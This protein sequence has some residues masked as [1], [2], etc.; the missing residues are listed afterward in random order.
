MRKQ[1]EYPQKY[2]YT[3]EITTEQW[4]ELLKNPEVFTEKDI[5]LLKKIYRFD[6]HE[7]TCFDLGIQD[8]KSPQ[9]YNSPVVN[10]GKRISRFL[11]LAP[12]LGYDGKSTW[13]CILF[14]GKYR[15]KKHF[16]WRIRPELVEAM[17]NVFPE[18]ENEHEDY[19]LVKQLKVANLL[20]TQVS[21]EYTGESQEKKAFIN[22]GERKIYP[23]D[24][25]KAIN[26]LAH[27][28]FV[29]EINKGH[30]TFIRRNSDKEYTE[31]HHLI[32]LAYY[33]QFDVCLDVEENIVSLCSTC[34]NHIHYGQGFEVLLQKLYSERKQ[35][36][37]KV[38]IVVSFEELLKMY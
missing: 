23:R 26:A 37:E 36:L 27:A 5:E 24:R 14:W 7:T 15:D 9:S 16:E 17:Q 34:H 6:N 35:H 29:C 31:P 4:K 19:T 12:L 21:F 28:H 22:S 10:L 8:G 11:S 20:S 2:V 3:V 25:E 13:W 18:L 32:P 1:E 30:P 38:G 33:N